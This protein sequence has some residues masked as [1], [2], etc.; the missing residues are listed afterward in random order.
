[1]RSTAACVVYRCAH[2]QQNGCRSRYNTQYK[3]SR[4]RPKAVCLLGIRLMA[5]IGRRTRTVRIADRF[6]FSAL[7]AYSTALKYTQTQNR[8]KIGQ[9]LT[10][11]KFN[12]DFFIFLLL[13][14]DCFSS[15]CWINKIKFVAAAPMTSS[16]RHRRL[17]IFVGLKPLE[18]NFSKMLSFRN[19]TPSGHIG[20][21]AF[22]PS[23]V[24][25]VASF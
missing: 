20:P 24:L 17:N 15:F 1:L 11:T 8:K 23:Y 16:E 2:A 10:T 3:K 5:L 25:F 22:S 7:M 14:R 13:N 9:N 6:K 21:L 19:T 4:A 12:Q 18:I